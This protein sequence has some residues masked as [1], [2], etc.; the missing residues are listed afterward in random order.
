MKA[1]SKE[2]LDRA[3]AAMVAAIEVYNKPSFLFRLE[4][5]A[6]LAVNAWELLL[7][8]KWL[9]DHHNDVTTLYVREKTGNSRKPLKRPR[10]KRSRSDNPITHSADYLAA[11]LVQS[12]TLEIAAQKNLEGL[13][14]LRDSVVHFYNRSPLFAQRLQEWGAAAVKNFVSAVKDWFRRDLMELNFNLMPLAFVGLPDQAQAIVLN[15]E[16][17]NFLAF[18]QSLE[19]PQADPAARYSVS[20]NIEVRFT[21]SKAKDALAVQ[22]TDNPDAPAVRLTEEQIKERYPWD[23]KQLTNECRK[24]YVDFKVNRDYHQRRKKF[25]GNKRFCHVRELDPGNPKSVKKMFYNPNIL[26][27]LDKY[28]TP[29]ET[30]NAREVV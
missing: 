12:G 4:A 18:L 15:A 23:Y 13:L 25:D 7:K 27:E 6:V 20:V 26:Q 19:P 10:F 17:K 2:L 21:K 9:A 30:K 3:I 5:F 29:K 1:R 11:K 16:E 28:Y 8:A 14:E 22:V 24:R